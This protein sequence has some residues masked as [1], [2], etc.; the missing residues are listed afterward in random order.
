[1]YAHAARFG[2]VGQNVSTYKEI[3]LKKKHIHTHTHAHKLKRAK[4]L[5]LEECTITASFFL[6]LAVFKALNGR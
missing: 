2:Y 1:M 3:K 5:A 4:L 6:I